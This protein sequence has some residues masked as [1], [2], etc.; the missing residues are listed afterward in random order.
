MLVGEL[1]PPGQRAA[2]AE[3]TAAEPVDAAAELEAAA[4]VVVDAESVVGADVGADVVDADSAA[5]VH[6]VAALCMSAATSKCPS[7]VN[8][9]PLGCDGCSGAAVGNSFEDEVLWRNLLSEDS[10]APE[11][12][13][14]RSVTETQT[15]TARG[16]EEKT[17]RKNQREKKSRKK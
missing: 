17:G 4:V 9:G 10:Q 16:S 14:R 1:S 15:Q 6:M 12:E 7:G 3:A 2:A 11:L 5:C 8:G 13:L